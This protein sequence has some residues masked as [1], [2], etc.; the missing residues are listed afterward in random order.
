MIEAFFSGVVTTARL[1]GFPAVAFFGGSPL[2]QA[3]A[4][5]GGRGFP[6]LPH[7]RH[8]LSHPKYLHL[9]WV[10]SVRSL[11]FHKGRQFLLEGCDRAFSLAF[12]ARIRRELVRPGASDSGDI[13]LFF[14][15]YRKLSFEK[16]PTFHRD[17]P[18]AGPRLH[19]S[20]PKAT[21]LPPFLG[22]QGEFPTQKTS[23]LFFLRTCSRPGETSSRS[24]VYSPT[25]FLRGQPSRVGRSPAYRACFP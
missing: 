16:M 6:S 25:E 24:A 4:V 19:P 12:P 15:R 10:F 9:E 11:P 20:L 13:I 1:P 2:F 21:P 17:R 7:R 5:W 14:L 22:T 3:L 23:M 18:V 8:P